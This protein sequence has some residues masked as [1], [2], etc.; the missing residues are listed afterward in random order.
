MPGSA[1]ELNGEVSINAPVVSVK[2]YLGIM[3]PKLT[4]DMPVQASA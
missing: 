2:A 4:A 3:L 1:R